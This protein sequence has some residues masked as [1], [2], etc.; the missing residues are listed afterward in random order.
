MTRK[1]FE[2]IAETM[3]QIKEHAERSETLDMWRI[4]V[5]A[6]AL[7]LDNYYPN[8][9]MDKFIKVCKGE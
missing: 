1:D 7:K 3:Y 4:T 5:N 8:F 6:L 9:D 2:R